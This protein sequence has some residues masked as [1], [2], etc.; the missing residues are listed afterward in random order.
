[1]VGCFFSCQAE[2]DRRPAIRPGGGRAL[3]VN[4]FQTWE[5]GMVYSAA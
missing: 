5:S 1:M 2:A 3:P 4:P